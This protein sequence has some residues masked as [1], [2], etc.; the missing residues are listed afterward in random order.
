M[1]FSIYNINRGKMSA[2]LTTN[3]HRTGFIVEIF[4]LLVLILGQTETEEGKNG[5]GWTGRRESGVFVFEKG[6]TF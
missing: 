4:P 5:R 3:L 2:P 1:V 6:N